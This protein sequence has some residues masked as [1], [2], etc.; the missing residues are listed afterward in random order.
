VAD[1]TLDMGKGERMGKG[2]AHIGGRPTCGK[3][4]AAAALQFCNT[5]AIDDRL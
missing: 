2:A 1:I 3:A 4:S 5:I